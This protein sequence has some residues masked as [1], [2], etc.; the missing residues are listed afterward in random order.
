MQDQLS[1]IYVTFARFTNTYYIDEHVQK[2]NN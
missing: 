2:N 1:I